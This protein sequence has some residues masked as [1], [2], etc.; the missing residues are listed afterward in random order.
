MD[1]YRLGVTKIQPPR[2]RATRSERP[3]LDAALA[4]ALRER[5]VVL[6]QAAAAVGAAARPEAGV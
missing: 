4:G 6:L 3:A 1:A 5:P 2:T